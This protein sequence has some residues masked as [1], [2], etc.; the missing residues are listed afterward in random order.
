MPIMK[1]ESG[2]VLKW[3]RR[4]LVT[5]AAGSAAVASFIFLRDLAIHAGWPEPIAIL[6]P[7]SLDVLAAA[8]LTEYHMSG[9]KTA[10]RIAVG[11]ISSSAVG[12]AF[13]HLYTTGANQ[14]GDLVTPG[15]VAIMLV[16]SVPAITVGIV[17][18][19]FAPRGSTWHSETVTGSAHGRSG[20]TASSSDTGKKTETLV[21]LSAP[22]AEHRAN[23]SERPSLKP[24]ELNGSGPRGNGTARSKRRSDIELIRLVSEN[25]WQNETLNSLTSKLSVSKV[26]ATR[27]R[28]AARDE[29]SEAVAPSEGN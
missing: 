17:I 5:I 8:A 7:L 21:P 4:A 24:S 10:G 9:S 29:L 27:I 22:A 11:V 15:W 12:N 3:W 6:L 19:I 18:H 2:T 20:G 26:R 14:P 28:Q 1:P 13:S 25:S 23:G 16:G